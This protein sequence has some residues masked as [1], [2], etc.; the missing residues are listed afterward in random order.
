MKKQRS[1][2]FGTTR[3]NSRSKGANQLEIKSNN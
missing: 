3:E 2:I 1:R